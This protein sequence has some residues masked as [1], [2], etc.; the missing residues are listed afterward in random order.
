MVRKGL[1][2]GVV[3]VV[4]AMMLAGCS[5]APS[6]QDIASNLLGPCG[7]PVSYAD[8]AWSPD[9]SRVAFVQYNAER[10]QVFVINA[11]GGGLTRISNPVRSSSSPSWSAD[12]KQL[13]FI[14][15]VPVS[16]ERPPDAGVPTRID[17]ANADG[18]GRTASTPSGNYL[19]PAWSPEPGATGDGARI[20]FV[21]TQDDNTDLYLMDADG[22]NIARLTTA[23]GVD[24]RPVWS[25][26]GKRIAF[27]SER[28][29]KPGLYVINRN[30]TGETRLDTRTVSSPSWSPVGGMLAYMA[31]HQDTGVYVI[32][33]ED[34]AQPWS[35]DPAGDPPPRV[36][37][38][39]ASAPGWFSDGKSILF[40][41]SSAGFVRANIDGSGYTVLTDPA[42][43]DRQPALSPDGKLIAYLTYRLGAA[44]EIYVMNADGSNQTQ[45]TV[46]P[47][48]Q[49]CLQW[50][51]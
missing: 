11:S 21:M 22:T 51:F 42:N 15:E 20:A 23:P 38:E 16:N 7:P 24:L 30:G 27:I 6:P 48:N 3:A 1:L 26:D 29:Y 37:G 17:I 49:Q 19:M 47:A 33:V 36:A 14:T 28:T 4:A 32:P 18:S 10:G 12:G 35:P 2:S 44:E 13:V 46:N 43:E 34:P 31:P 41:D 5:G 39:P 25:P 9:S 8:L 45:L 50:P 40:D